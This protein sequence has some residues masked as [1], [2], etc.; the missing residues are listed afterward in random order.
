MIGD[1]VIS[2][3]L[4]SLFGLSLVTVGF[5]LYEQYVGWFKYELPEIKHPPSEVQVRILTIGDDSNVVQQT[6]DA[7]PM[8]VDDVHVISE[9]NITIDGAA[10]NVVPASFSCE[11]ERKGRAL[12]WGRRNI[13]CDTEYILYLDEDTQAV[14]FDGLPDADVVQFGEKPFETN[15]KVAYW[16]EVFRMGFQV[17]MRAFSM[18][19]VPLYAWGGGIAIRRELEDEITWNFKSIV[20]DTSFVWRSTENRD[21]EFEYCNDKFRNQAPPSITA[22]INQRRRWFAGSISELDILPRK[23]YSIAM[24]RNASWALTIFLPV[25]ISLSWV[26]LGGYTM[27]YPLFYITSSV[28]LLSVVLSWAA[29][30]CLY[31]DEPPLFAV[32]IFALAP[33]LSLINAVGALYGLI[34][35]PDSFDVTKKAD[36]TGPTSEVEAPE[37]TVPTNVEIESD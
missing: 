1:L 24:L 35:P 21:I 3:L 18:F 27:S 19:D 29:V 37:Q 16:V 15:S 36:T 5:W 9:Q 25:M 10:V 34:S 4:W 23:Y 6:V 2:V 32:V 31:M 8:E 22:L 12:E 28:I 17:E 11:A 30:G 7:L 13:A 14:N 33:G 20:E 26:G